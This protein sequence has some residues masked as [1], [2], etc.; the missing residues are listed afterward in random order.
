[1]AGVVEAQHRVLARCAELR[2]RGRFVARHVAAKAGQK[3]DNRTGT[4]QLYPGEFG[5]ITAIEASG[6]FHL[7]SLMWPPWF[8]PNRHFGYHAGASAN[9]ASGRVTRHIH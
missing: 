7:A 3:Y 4:V 2:Q 1:M 5:S 8:G 6:G 9:T